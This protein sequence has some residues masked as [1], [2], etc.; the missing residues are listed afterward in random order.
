MSDDLLIKQFSPVVYFHTKEKIFPID[1]NQYLKNCEIRSKDDPSFIQSTP[2]PA[3]MF[4]DYLNHSLPN[5][6]YLDLLDLN[7]LQGDPNKT[8]TYAKLSKWEGGPA[9]LYYYFYFKTNPENCCYCGWKWSCWTHLADIKFMALYLTTDSQSAPNYGGY[10]IKKAYFGAHSTYAGQWVNGPDLMY[11][12]K[13]HPVTYACLNDHS[14][15]HEPIIYPR[16]FFFSCDE[17]EQGIRSVPEV[18]R[19]YDQNEEDFNKETAWYYFNGKLS[20]DGIDPP[21]NTGE[22]NPSNIPTVSSN[23]FKRLFCCK[24][25]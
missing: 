17:C 6:L 23:W 24:Y 14:F 10:S 12:E 16:I 4:N 13:T 19:I 9:I 11:E 22:W 8:V 21:A 5:N 1:I 2:T 20:Q 15:Y 25:F 18:V 7:N 3:L